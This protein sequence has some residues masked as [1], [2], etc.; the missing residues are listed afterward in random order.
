MNEKV[1]ARKVSI[2]KERDLFGGKQQLQRAGPFTGWTRC[3]VH[4]THQELVNFTS[5][6]YK[7]LIGCKISLA[8]SAVRSEMP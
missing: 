1:P 2:L 5:W 8:Y 6:L 7:I 3:A 4:I